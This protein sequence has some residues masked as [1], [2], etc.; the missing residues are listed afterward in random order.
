M[1]ACLRDGEGWDWVT[2]C[3]VLVRRLQQLHPDDELLHAAVLQVAK[4]V[5][6]HHV[7]RRGFARHHG[8]AVVARREGAAGDAMSDF[9][10]TDLNSKATW[11]GIQ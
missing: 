4:L 9:A 5:S 8:L 1:T 10:A 3:R 11:F 2:C 6:R 7:V